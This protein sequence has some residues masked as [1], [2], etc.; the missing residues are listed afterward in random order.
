MSKLE[1]EYFEIEDMEFYGDEFEVH[2]PTINQNDF[3]GLWGG[4]MSKTQ[5]DKLRPEHMTIGF[6]DYR[7]MTKE[8]QTFIYKALVPAE[9]YE[10]EPKVKF[11]LE[12]G[13]YIKFKSLFREHGPAFFQ[14][15]YKYMQE[16]N[17]PFEG[18]FDFELMYGDFYPDDE[19]AYCYVCLKIKE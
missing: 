16:E 6:E 14:R 18:W 13:K 8:N 12:K 5:T 7:N 15:V 9:F 1:F 3:G 2:L 11:T 19:D 17:I 4:V 10:G